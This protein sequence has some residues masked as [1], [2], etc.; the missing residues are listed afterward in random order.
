MNTPVYLLTSTQGIPII[1]KC[2][3]EGDVEKFSTKRSIILGQS[4]AEANINSG[5]WVKETNSDRIAKIIN[6]T[7]YNHECWIQKKDAFV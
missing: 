5:Q 6:S 1:V 2:E 4:C 3:E 7:F